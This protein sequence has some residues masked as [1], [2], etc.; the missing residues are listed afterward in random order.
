[1][2]GFW[3]SSAGLDYFRGYLKRLRSTSRADINRYVSTYIQGKP[4][5]GLAV[6]SPESLRASGLTNADLIGG[7]PVAPGA[8]R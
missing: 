4:H 8:V 1:V 3:W 7:A 6:L 2:I 5:V